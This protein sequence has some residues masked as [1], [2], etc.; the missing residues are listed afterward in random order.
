MSLTLNAT[1][2]ECFIKPHI[3][4]LDGGGNIILAVNIV[5]NIF[6]ML[7]AILGNCSILLS[8][9]FVSSLRST[10]NYLLFGLAV[11][12]LGVGFVVHPLYIFV[13][14]RVYNNSTPHCNV[15][16]AYSVATSL[17]G[18]VSLLYITVI[19]ID[20]HLAIK[21]HLRYRVLVTEKRT[22]IAQIAVW[23]INGLLSLVWLKGFRTYSGF[24]AVMIIFSLLASFY[25]YIKMYWVVKR[26]T[27]QI[28]F[29]MGSQMLHLE[30]CRL[31][32]LRKS[33]VNTMYVFFVFLLCYLPFCTS[34]MITNISTWPN[35]A[36]ILS[37][38]L[39]ATILLSNSSLNPLMYCLRFREFRIAVKKTYRILFCLNE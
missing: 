4:S 12:D 30:F 24:A 5:A 13:L 18:G 14:F 38:E 1:R 15:M 7:T 16:A 22:N 34:T 37:F 25:V 35:K 19:G 3:L 23:V 2:T 39:S 26:H 21:L 9:V 36:G 11:T 31:K 32:R 10:S 17:L 27:G 29:Q 6:L 20:R 8:F 33:A 28:H